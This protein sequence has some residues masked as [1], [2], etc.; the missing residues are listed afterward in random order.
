MRSCLHPISRGIQRTRRAR[1]RY[2]TGRPFAVCFRDEYS[3]GFFFAR[4]GGDKEFQDLIF[5]RPDGTQPRP[6]GQQL[7]I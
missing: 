4:A 3:Y 2:N 7:L 5:T 6:Q 1:L